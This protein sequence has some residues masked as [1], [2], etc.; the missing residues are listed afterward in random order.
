ME[1]Q[2]IHALRAL[3]RPRQNPSFKVTETTDCLSLEGGGAMGF[4]KVCAASNNDK[5]EPGE[6]TVISSSRP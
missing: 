6:H 1:R 3:H 5:L 4:I 2:R